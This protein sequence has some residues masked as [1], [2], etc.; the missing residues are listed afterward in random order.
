[1][2]RVRKE[3]QGY[4]HCVSLEKLESMVAIHSVGKPV[5]TGV[6]RKVMSLVLDMF[7]VKDLLD[8]Q[9]ERAGRQV[10]A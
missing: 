8:N 3:K 6:R 9:V 1:M 10:N 2:G 5:G 4:H 7:S